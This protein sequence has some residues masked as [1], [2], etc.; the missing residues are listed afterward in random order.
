MDRI[1]AGIFAF[2]IGVPLIL[3]V[4]LCYVT[5]TQF[6]LTMFTGIVVLGLAVGM[7]FEIKRMVDLPPS[8]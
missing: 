7:I 1:I 8:H 3:M 2:I 6:I 4:A 5:G